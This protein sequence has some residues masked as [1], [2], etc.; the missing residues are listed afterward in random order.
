MDNSWCCISFYSSISYSTQSNNRCIC[1]TYHSRIWMVKIRTCWSSN[2]R[3]NIWWN[4]C[5]INWSNCGQI[6]TKMGFIFWIPYPW[7]TINWAR[8]YS[9]SFSFLHNYCHLKNGSPRSYQYNLSNNC[10][11]MVYTA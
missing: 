5:Y 8:K 2:N 10:N 1:Y 4:S 6:W 9:K 3:H 11:K 7:I